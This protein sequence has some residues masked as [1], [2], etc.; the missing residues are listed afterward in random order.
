MSVRTHMCGVRYI[1]SHVRDINSI[2]AILPDCLSRVQVTFTTDSWVQPNAIIT[3]VAQNPHPCRRH[4]CLDHKGT[5]DIYLFPNRAADNS[6]AK[7]QEA[8]MALDVPSSRILA[9]LAL[10]QYILRCGHAHE[11]NPNYPVQTYISHLQI[12]VVGHGIMAL[13]TGVSFPGQFHST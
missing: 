3:M 2:G 4:Y 12:E 11:A 6:S 10:G 5:S 13:S 7:V 9:D 1:N 8:L